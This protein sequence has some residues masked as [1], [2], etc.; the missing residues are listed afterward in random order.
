MEIPIDEYVVPIG[1]AKIV[2]EG[3]HLTL[4]AHGRMVLLC[5]KVIDELAKQGIQIELIDLRTIKPLD[6]ATIANSVRK[7]HHAV[8][9]EE[10]HL[11]TGICAEV[12]FEIQEHCFDFLDAPIRRVT[13]CETPMPYSKAL[14]KETMPT[15]ERITQAILETLNLGT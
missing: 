5:K 12:G 3:N 9:V 13:Q 8:L 1:K 4:V 2:S 7:T 14:E 10:G 15:T 6:I 11:F